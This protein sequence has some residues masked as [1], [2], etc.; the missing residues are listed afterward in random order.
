MD[1]TPLILLAAG[2]LPYQVIVLADSEA[3]PVE[4]ALGTADAGLELRGCLG[5]CSP[6]NQVPIAKAL[7]PISTVSLARLE[8]AM[9]RIV[10]AHDS[11]AF[12]VLVDQRDALL[13][14]A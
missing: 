1:N 7:D 8:G 3:E 6:I 5:P 11:R 2:G 4:L 9:D 10:G 13:A 12:D 14:L